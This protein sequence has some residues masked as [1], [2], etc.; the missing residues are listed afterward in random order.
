MDGSVHA[1]LAD[2]WFVLIGLILMLYVITDGFD[3]GV[4][5]V[6]LFACDEERRSLMMASL[7]SVWD[8]NETWLVLLGGALFGAFPLAYATLM[9]ALYIPLIAMLAGLIFRAVA[10]EFRE[11]AQR[12][13][14]WNIAFGA[15]SLLAALSQGFALGAV[16]GGLPVEGGHYVGGAWDWLTPFSSLVAVGV[17]AGYALL[18]S[19]YLI[20]KTSGEVQ[21]RSYRRALIAAGLMGLAGIA[22]SFW[23]PLLH[24]GVAHERLEVS[25]LYYLLPLPVL[26]LVAFGLL[27]RAL[28]QRHEV[29]P[30]LWSIAIFVLSFAGLAVI[31]YPHLIPPSVTVYQAAAPSRTLVF[32]LSGIGMLLPIM[33]VYNAY[34]YM[35]F[36]GKVEMPGYGEEGASAETH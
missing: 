15:G 3:L 22:V 11:L 18:G 36:R 14:P 12:K 19:T 28:M 5:V 35:V 16:M 4:G 17:V 1:F 34:Q 2:I 10:F 9:H 27:L 30:F 26:A 20:I 33:L 8:A 31:L 13:Q 7:G 24:E 23:T 25:M 6:S 32:M 21:Q 29:A